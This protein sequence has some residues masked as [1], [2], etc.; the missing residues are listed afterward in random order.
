MIKLL[1]TYNKV[2]DVF[3]KPKIKFYISKC[4]MGPY[5]K[6]YSHYHQIHYVSGR[7]VIESGKETITCDNGHSYDVTTF[8]TIDHKMP[9]KTGINV[10][11]SAI[12]RKLRKWYLSWIPPIIFLP[13]FFK[14]GINNY[15]IGWKTKWDEY[16][17][18]TSP[19]FTITL[20]GINFTWTAIAPIDSDDYWEAILYYLD[21]HDL[22]KVNAAMGQWEETSTH[23]KRNRFN[24]EILKEPYKSQLIKIQTY[25]KPTI[26]ITTIE[27]DS[28]FAGSIET[29]EQD[30]KGHTD[31][32][33]TETL[34]WD[35]ITF[36]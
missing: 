10:W 29:K 5:L 9:C 34:T 33:E 28:I 32:Y 31:S 23:K 17:F 18:E 25:A 15:D 30:F 7:S 11:N 16:R 3:V 12:R 19:I 26:K 14:F 35:N 6:L 2:K 20:F 24:P 4:Y 13:R 36:N 22:K 27:K 21:S 1:N 8:I